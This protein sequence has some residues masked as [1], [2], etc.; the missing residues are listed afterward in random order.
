MKTIA[1]LTGLVALSGY[2]SARR[3]GDGSSSS[4]SSGST[5]SYRSGYSSTTSSYYMPSYD[6]AGYYDSNTQMTY[7]DGY[8]SNTESSYN[9]N[10]DG[11][12]GD[13]Q[14]FAANLG[15]DIRFNMTTSGDEKK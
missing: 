7:Y 4:D 5:S 8:S 3:G 9:Y 1:Y 15:D 2:V 6:A 14:T 12:G 10:Y 13:G 11:S